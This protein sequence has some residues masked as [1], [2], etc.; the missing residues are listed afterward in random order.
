MSTDLTIQIY[1]LLYL[2]EYWNYYLTLLF[3][4]FFCSAFSVQTNKQTW[5]LVTPSLFLPIK[6]LTHRNKY[7][8]VTWYFVSIFYSNNCGIYNIYITKYISVLNPRQW[9]ATKMLSEAFTQ[10]KK[11][12]LMKL[13][14]IYFYIGNYQI[15][16]HFQTDTS[17]NAVVAF[18]IFQNIKPS[19][20]M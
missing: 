11:T 19:V 8:T 5:K 18:R 17:Y 4:L 6:T 13:L 14:S 15:V 9:C 1:A 12:S 3:I 20:V 16:R 10:I 7:K 2:L